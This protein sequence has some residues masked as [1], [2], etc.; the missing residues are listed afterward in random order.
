MQQSLC[1]YKNKNTI[2]NQKKGKNLI[3]C[4]GRVEDFILGSHHFQYDDVF[5]MLQSKVNENKVCPS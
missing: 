3:I 4:L 1:V 2:V 5:Q